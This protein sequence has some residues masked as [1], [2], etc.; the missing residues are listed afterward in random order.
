MLIR[1]ITAIIL[2]A[3]MAAVVLWAPPI[4]F[5]GIVLLVIVGGLY[6]FFKL[7]L[8]P[9][10]IYREAA[11]IWGLAL[12]AGILFFGEPLVTLAILLGGLFFVMLVHMRHSTVMEGITSRIGITTLG[13]IYLGA[14]LPFW[15]LL[16][17]L[18]H[19]RALIFI[20]I[21]AAA[22]SDTFAFFV[23]R[24]I[25]RRKLARL[26]SP[27]KTVEGFV[28]GFFGSVLGVYLAKIISWPALSLIHVLILGLAIGFVGPMGDLIESVFKR[29]YHVKDTGHVIP[30]HG[31]FLDRLDA[32]VFTGPLVYLYA[33]LILQ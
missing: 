11:L 27:N 26:V 6:E 13:V 4:V 20:G 2:A 30:G 25:G 18:D 23:G 31:G 7:A 28:A 1:I 3:L 19:G 29:D 12:A 5:N 14:T 24:A 33:K 9:E 21:A 32:M 15:G 22:L 10:A 8:P 17:V 16:R